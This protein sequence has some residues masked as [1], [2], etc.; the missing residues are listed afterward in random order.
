MHTNN[1]KSN[2]VKPKYSIYLFKNTLGEKITNMGGL[3]DQNKCQVTKTKKKDNKYSNLVEQLLKKRQE[4]ESKGNEFS[5]QCKD[6]LALYEREEIIEFLKRIKSEEKI[7]LQI[8]NEKGDFAKNLITFEEEVLNYFLFESNNKKDYIKINNSK[9]ELYYKIENKGL[10][11]LF[12]KEV[13]INVIHFL[14]LIYE[15]EYYPKWFPFNSSTNCLVQPGK[16]KKLI[17]MVSNLPVISDR[18]FLVYGFGI[19]RMKE[20]GTIML[21]C[22]SVLENSGIFTEQFKKRAN[23]KYVRA[24]I[25]IFGFEIKIINRNKVFV[26]GLINTDPKIGVIPQWLVNSVS[27]K[28]INYI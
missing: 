17:H 20:N 22:R 23:K 4:E 18:D 15:V 21:L 8:F 12:E 19:N 9:F 5:A 25:Q 6:V 11:L 1:H 26:K 2:G 27:Q 3:L 13:D 16:A 28:V 7:K 14:S 24:E 10:T